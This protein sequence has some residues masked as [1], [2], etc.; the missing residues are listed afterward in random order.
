MRTLH[1]TRS[2]YIKSIAGLQVFHSAGVTWF[3]LT[4]L[5]VKTTTPVCLSVR[6]TTR[7]LQH[8]FHLCSTTLLTCHGSRSVNC[9]DARLRMEMKSIRI[10]ALLR[11][12]CVFRMTESLDPECPTA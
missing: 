9:A 12:R 4:E 6:T 11:T 1:R 5:S 7:I 2:G 3:S 8:R 10:H